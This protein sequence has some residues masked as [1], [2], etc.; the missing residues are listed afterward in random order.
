MDE[1]VI[2]R[3]IRYTVWYVAAVW[4]LFRVIGAVGTTLL[5]YFS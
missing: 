1:K 4:L 5:E 3:L 2:K